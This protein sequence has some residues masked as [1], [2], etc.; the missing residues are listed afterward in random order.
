MKKKQNYLFNFR[1]DRKASQVGIILSFAI[2]IS[3]LI[4]FFSIVESPIRMQ[5]EK[6]FILNQF[7]TELIKNC[8]GEMTTMTILLNKNPENC[9]SIRNT[10]RI[11]PNIVVKNGTGKVI[12]SSFA[13]NRINIKKS[14]RFYKIFSSESFEDNNNLDFCPPLDKNNY[15]IG[16]VKTENY[17]FENKI[18]NLLENKK[19]FNIPSTNSLDFSFTYNNGTTIGNNNLNLSTN[20]YTRKVYIQYVDENA[21]ILGGAINLKIW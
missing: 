2:F 15:T 8:S 9:F 20:I 19:S 10:T 7:E 3:F 6:S 5:K 1:K 4:F 12:N 11:Y 21:N 17:V 16:F 14:N 18:I 13:S